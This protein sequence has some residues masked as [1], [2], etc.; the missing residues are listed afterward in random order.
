MATLSETNGDS[1][2]DI[3]TEYLTNWNLFPSRENT[4][5]EARRPPLDHQE[6]N[7]WPPTPSTPPS[8]ASQHLLRR[9]GK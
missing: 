7:Q 8:T 1:F 3:T 2:L 5:T 6:D 9:G 4:R